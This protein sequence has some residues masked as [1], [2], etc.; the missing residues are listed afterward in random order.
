MELLQRIRVHLKLREGEKLIVY[1]DT[2]GNPTGGV[3]HLVT[4]EDNLK[5]GDQITQKQSDAF[6]RK[7]M[8]KAFFA[9]QAQAEKIGIETDEFIL[10][11][12]SVNFQLGTDWPA[13]F[14]GSY[15]ELV[16]GNWQN[17]IHGFQNSKWAEQTPVRVADFVKA[18]KKAYNTEDKTFT[19]SGDLPE[20]DKRKRDGILN[21]IYNLVRRLAGLG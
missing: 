21:F 14:F 7:D 19:Q 10:A 1:L 18:I 6:L 8:Q 20:N 2:L 15:P 13:V 3:G 16:R 4:S 12:T 17:A 9:A 5:V 11:L